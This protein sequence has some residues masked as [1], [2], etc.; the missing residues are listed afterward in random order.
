MAEWLGWI[1]GVWSGGEVI[2]A[3]GWVECEG[4]R[5]GGARVEAQKGQSREEAAGGGS[6]LCRGGRRAAVQS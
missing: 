5:C 2:G 4:V 3:C 6:V 1:C